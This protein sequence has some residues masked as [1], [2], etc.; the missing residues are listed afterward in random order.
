M[1]SARI[2]VGWTVLVAVTAVH[3]QTPPYDTTTVAEAEVRCGPSPVYY[4]TSKLKAG[5][6]VRVVAEKE[7]GWLAIEPPPGSFSWVNGRL[8]GEHSAK[9]AVVYAPEAPVLAGSALVDRQPDVVVAKLP[10]GSQV[11]IL[12]EARVQADGSQW[13]PIMPQKELR[14]LRK[15]AVRAQTPVEAIGGAGPGGVAPAVA[16]TG[17]DALWVQAEQAREAGKV[18][19]ARQLYEACLR[20]PG[21]DETRRARCTERLQQLNA[22]QVV[23]QPIAPAPPAAPASPPKVNMQPPTGTNPAPGTQGQAVG[24]GVR[25]LDPQGATVSMTGPGR[26]RRAGFFIDGKQ[27]YALEDS[28]G[29]L[30]M[31]VTAQ[32]GLDLEPHINRNVNLAG[33]IVYHQQLRKDYI[34]A[35]QVMPLP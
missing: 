7:G 13:W 15:E 33:M 18:A 30:R 8:L 6:P 10:R 9:T 21:L 28:Q 5:T 4:A 22:G 17:V 16:A 19:E 23:V 2:I 35:S 29:Q 14:Y 20:Q 25:T 12:G 3:G 1:R 31:Y 24:Y 34:L 11:V 32:A 26:L 27:A